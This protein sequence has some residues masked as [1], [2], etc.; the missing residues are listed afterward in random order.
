MVLAAG[1]LL[2]H[3]GG[4]CGEQAGLPFGLGGEGAGLALGVEVER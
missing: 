4:G 2:R 1:R 3:L